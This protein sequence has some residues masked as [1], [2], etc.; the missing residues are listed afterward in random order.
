LVEVGKSECGWDVSAAA[1]SQPTR[2][3]VDVFAA[4]IGSDFSKY[5][6]AKGFLRWS[7]IHAAPD[8][9][10]YERLQWATLLQAINQ[11]LG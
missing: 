2:G 8:L 7:R 9:T 10:D 5:R 11:A 1:S 3:I 4:E 6:L